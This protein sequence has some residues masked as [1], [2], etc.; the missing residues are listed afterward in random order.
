MQFNDKHYL[1]WVRIDQLPLKEAFVDFYRCFI[2]TAN[3][4]SVFVLQQCGHKLIFDQILQ[5][6]LSDINTIS[7]LTNVPSVYKSMVCHYH[8]L[9]L[10]PILFVCVCVCVCVRAST[11]D[12]NLATLKPTYQLKKDLYLHR[13]ICS[14]NIKYALWHPITKTRPSGLKYISS[15]MKPF[16]SR[17]AENVKQLSISLNAWVENTA[18]IRAIAWISWTARLAMVSY[19]EISVNITAFNYEQNIAV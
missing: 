13:K 5:L 3:A 4:V 1:G 14:R 11:I 2:L 6:A 10:Q 18:S 16:P 7:Y 8:L 17:H 15:G 12:A 9:L 19:T